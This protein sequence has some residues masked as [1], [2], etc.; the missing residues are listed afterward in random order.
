[1]GEQLA[2]IYKLTSKVNGFIYIGQTTQTL[3]ERIY[4]HIKSSRDTTKNN[5]P[6][7]IDI[8]EFGIEKF[9]AEIVDTCFERHKF[10]LEEYWF[11]Y[12]FD[13]G[14][15]MYDI[16]IGSKHSKNTRQRMAE[17]REKRNFD[18][19]S[20][21][22][23]VKISEKTSGENNGMFGRKNSDAVNG[24]MVIA[25]DDKG[26]IIHEFV[27]VKTALQYIGIKGHIG[28]NNACKTGQK[29]KGYYWKKEWVKR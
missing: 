9:D 13:N 27:S 7:Y 2:N 19:D 1:M 12:Y 22:F 14:F 5:R 6:L 18:Y 26:D 16:K 25:L 20:P 28:L 4:N 8:N 15:P 21:E 3:E 17:L 29:Y 23:K 11:N 24:R 10:I